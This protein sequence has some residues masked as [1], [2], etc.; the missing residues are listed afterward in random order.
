[1]FTHY[2][3]F[4]CRGTVS[5]RRAPLL[6]RLLARADSCTAVT[7]WRAD[8]FSVIAPVTASMP[9]VGAAALCSELGTQD[10][11]S[12]LVATPVH[13]QVESSN[14]RLP[15]EGILSLRVDEADVLS[16]EFN[17][18]WHDAGIRMHAGRRGGLFCIADQPLTVS[19]HDPQDVLAQH[20]EMYL[21]SGKD[22]P[23][24]RRLM[25]EIEM[26]LFEHEVNRARIAAGMSALSS[27]WLWGAGPALTSLPQVTGWTAGDDVFFRCFAGRR[28]SAHTG[29][30]VVASTVEP[31]TDAWREFESRWLEGSLVDLRAGRIGRL[32]LSAGNRC[33][34][35]SRRDMWRFWR[36]GRPWWES[37]S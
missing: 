35:L 37:F 36:R 23:R 21:P 14:V 22:A 1:M 8:A 30:G 9:G 11:V 32:D 17:R 20:I 29:S 24:L 16:G 5:R 18:I 34:S 26:W 3:H 6:E 2:F 7:D 28:D 4:A 31:G 25:S 10:G 27:L 12:V 15:A 13:Y 19:T 33:L